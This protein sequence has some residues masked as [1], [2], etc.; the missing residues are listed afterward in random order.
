MMKIIWTYPYSIVKAFYFLSK[1]LFRTLH[2]MLHPRLILTQQYPNNRDTL[3]I[4]D[5]FKA[6]L[7]LIDDEQG[8]T[9]CTACGLCQLSC[10]NGSISVIA[11]SVQTPE[12]KTK[13]TLNSYTYQ[14]GN[15]TFCGLCVDSCNFGALE[16]KNDF[17]QSEYDRS[18]L[19]KIL[20]KSATV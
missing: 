20:Y 17:E 2:S 6:N 4:P 13:K 16:F 14:L 5:R 7:H 3:Y 8:N 9:K 12:G 10:P 11:G 18:K 1:G 19:E 15:C